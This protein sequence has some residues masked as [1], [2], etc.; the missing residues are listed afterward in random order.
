MTDI[1]Y[2]TWMLSGSSVM[3]DGQTIRNGYS[4]D[5]DSLSVGSRLGMMRSK[6]GGKILLGH[7][8]SIHKGLK[9]PCD[10]C[11]HKAS[12]KVESFL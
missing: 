9:Y 12:T 6:E 4:C 1:D 3:R 5:L 2:D 7:I 10:Q 11:D 8:K